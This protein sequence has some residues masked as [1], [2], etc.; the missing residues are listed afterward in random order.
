MEFIQLN[1]KETGRDARKKMLELQLKLVYVRAVATGEM[2][3]ESV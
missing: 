1:V 3:N 2:H